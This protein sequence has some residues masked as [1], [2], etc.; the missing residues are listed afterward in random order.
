MQISRIESRVG[1]SK[2]DAVVVGV[3]QDAP[4]EGA[5][6]DVDAALDGAVRGLIE[7]K[8][9]AGRACETA[10]LL[11]AGADRVPTIL[12]LVSPESCITPVG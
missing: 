4:L 10:R 6:A 7:S 1:E 3:H 5:A 12:L 9:F 8:E 2:A 11:G